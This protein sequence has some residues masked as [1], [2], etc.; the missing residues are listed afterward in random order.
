MR[1]AAPTRAAGRGDIFLAV[2]EQIGEQLTGLL[3]KHLCARWNRNDN[4][5]AIASGAATALT[6]TA[7]PTTMVAHARQFEQGFAV[8]VGAEDYVAAFAS[9]A[10][11]RAAHRDIF[12]AAKR[13][14]PIAAVAAFHFDI[15][16]VYKHCSL[17]D[18]PKAILT[19]VSPVTGEMRDYPT[20]L[21]SSKTFKPLLM[22]SFPRGTGAVLL[23]FG[24]L[25]F[26]GCGGG[27]SGPTP[28]P[29]RTPV[30]GVTPTPGGTPTSRNLIIV[31]LRDSGGAAVDGV[32]ALTVGADTFRLGTTGGQ[33][34]F[35]GFV[36]GSYAISAQVNGRTQSKTF[37]AA[38]GATTVD[39]VFPTGV[40][41]LPTG[42]IPPPPF[43]N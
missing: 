19:P 43:G 23:V 6:V 30:P 37:V 8:R 1:V 36:A 5:V 3:V 35:A 20:Q 26:A 9:V 13:D 29:T 18:E 15:R 2:H 11:R 22:F 34:S 17:L 33:A 10:A 24:A 4:F 42:T 31:R 12:F 41:P 39:I 25:W 7:T 40:V 16:F 21:D 14:N 27:S 32:V 28:S 38:A